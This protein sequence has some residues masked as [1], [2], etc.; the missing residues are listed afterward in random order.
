MEQNV[1]RVLFVA[2]S[3]F[4]LVKLLISEFREIVFYKKNN[5][6][7][8]K[9][10]QTDIRIYRGESYEEKNEYSNKS[11]VIYGK[12]IGIIIWLFFIFVFIF[13]SVK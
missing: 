1:F 6:N 10:S 5:W 3:G 4:F 13:E 12:P 2:M 11:R 8:S 9:D 7:F